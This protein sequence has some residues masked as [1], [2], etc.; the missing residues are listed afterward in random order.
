MSGAVLYPHQTLDG[1]L[2]LHLDRVFLDDRP[3][4]AD[5]IQREFSIADLGRDG[6]FDWTLARLHWTARLET[7]DDIAEFR[8][9]SEEFRE[10]RAWVA[11]ECRPTNLRMS[12]RLSPSE[13]SATWQGVMEIDRDNVAGSAKIQA[14]LAYDVD[15]DRVDQ[16]HRVASESYQWIVYLDPPRSFVREGGL[17]MVWVDFK[18]EDWL[19]DYG[20]AFSALDTSGEIPRIL[21]NSGI[22]GLQDLLTGE[23][24][25][26]VT[27]D[28]MKI[29]AATSVARGAWMALVHL[30]ITSLKGSGG[31]LE[32]WPGPFWQ[33]E[34]LQQLA[35]ILGPN[36]KLADWLKSDGADWIAHGLTPA[37]WSRLD[38]AMNDWLARRSG[39]SVAWTKWDKQRKISKPAKP[40]EEDPVKQGIL[41]RIVSRVA[42][43]RAGRDSV[44][45][46]DIDE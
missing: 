16:S 35:Q 18:E 9:L 7:D 25:G 34:V 24:A 6:Q 37:N 46:R 15:R 11:L 44:Q 3:L 42:K 41:S 45:S 26:D 17:P 28:S 21:L 13:D 33:R 12:L 30:S 8:R 1:D 22:P 27:L 23:S 31:S 39:L 43:P 5:R 14:W 32:D 4:P 20:Q 19:A 36:Q 10:L 38:A 2:R 29:L 40:E